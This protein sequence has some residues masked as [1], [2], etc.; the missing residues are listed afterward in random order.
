MTDHGP[1]HPAHTAHAGGGALNPGE[2]PVGMR[3]SSDPLLDHEYDGIREYDNPLPGWWVALLWATMIFSVVYVF[4]YHSG[5]E[6]RS[7]EGDY[8]S[9]VA[10]F[11][12]QLIARYGE[13]AA[14][15]DTILRYAQDPMAM[16]GMGS[17][18]KARCAQ[19]HANDGGGNIGPNLLDDHYI[20]IKDVADL[21]RVIKDGVV[22]KGMPAWGQQLSETQLVLMAAYVAQLRG[23]GA[24]GKQPE[25]NPIA[26]WPSAPVCAPESGT[27]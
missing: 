10:A 24:G 11:A 27:R 13:L 6:G 5:V 4:Y 20:H 2:I 1:A 19:C 22:A 23:Q 15:Q 9:E 26:P 14:D 21:Y 7:I 18:F 3:P 17:Q 25:G 12:Q 16:A 8:Q